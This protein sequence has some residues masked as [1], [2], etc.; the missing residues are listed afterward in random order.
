MGKKIHLC[1]TV[2]LGRG[3]NKEN[4]H[5]KTLSASVYSSK[6]YFQRLENQTHVK[7]N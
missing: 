4:L 6:I 5:L 3:E 1:F 7:N 2:N